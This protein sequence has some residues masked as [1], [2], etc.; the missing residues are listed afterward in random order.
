MSGKAEGHI[1]CT[2]LHPAKLGRLKTETK[3]LE[4]LHGRDKNHK[5]SHIVTIHFCNSDENDE[6]IR[7]YRI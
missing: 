1:F 2:L 6:I 3:P 4:D 7:T 5:P